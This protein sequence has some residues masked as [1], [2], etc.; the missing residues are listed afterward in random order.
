MRI[1]LVAL[2]LNLAVSTPLAAAVYPALEAPVAYRATAASGEV[3]Y[4]AFLRLLG[5]QFFVLH[6]RVTLSGKTV[7][8]KSRTGIWRQLGEGALLQL[9]SRNGPASR[10]NVGGGGNL[11]GDM[12]A[13]HFATA[14]VIFKKA[15]DAPRPYAIYGLLSFED[16]GVTLRDSASG[17]VFSLKSDPRLTALAAQQKQFF[18]EADVEADAEEHGR[19][20]RLVELHAA[21]TRLPNQA[22]PSAKLFDQMANGG[23][24]RMNVQGLPPLNCVFVSNGEGKGTFEASGQGLRLSAAY[25]AGE[26]A[27]AFHVN[28][29]DTQVLRPAGEE[30]LARLLESI[31]NWDTEG[32]IL[33]FSQKRT[34][35][36][37]LEKT[38]EFSAHAAGPTRSAKQKTMTGATATTPKTNTADK[39]QLTWTQWSFK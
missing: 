18:V 7:K 19:T 14:N 4:E 28:A 6:E 10:L 33:V 22:L 27:V 21:S 29:G 23:V 34:T 17:R 3:T 31:R 8:E 39:G 15:E 38:S 25:E 2:A 35:L 11:Y 16:N 12:R 1:L 30:A 20:L 32:E 5:G 13:T 36:C 9:A 26:N 37:I 24:W